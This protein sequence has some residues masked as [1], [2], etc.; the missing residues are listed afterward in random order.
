MESKKLAA[1]RAVEYVKSGMVVGLGTGSTV[2]YAIKR[3]GEKVKQG[4]DIRAIATSIE[5]ERMAK[6]L[7]IELI[8]F[9][10]IDAIDITIDGADEV[11]PNWNLIKG[12]G[13][14]LLREK[15]TA[16]A[17]RQL[18]VIVDESKVVKQLGRFPLPIE[19]VKFGYEMTMKKFEELGFNPKLRTVHGRPYITDNGNYI[20]DCHIGLIDNPPQL[21]D[22]INQLV[23]VVDNGLFINYASKVIVGY[24]NQSVIEL[25]K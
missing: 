21:H 19:V 18:I 23:G 25:K 3:L 1:E 6:E 20:I 24:E 22:L 7:G 4:L 8:T 17:S 11:D 16:A 5:S 15:I 12:G 13:G 2:Y 14:A 9:S 10:N